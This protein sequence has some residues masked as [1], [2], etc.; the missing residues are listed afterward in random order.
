MPFSPTITTPS[1]LMSSYNSSLRPFQ[2][3]YKVTSPTLSHSNNLH[4]TYRRTGDAGSRD[5]WILGKGGSEKD[6]WSVV[7]GEKRYWDSKL[8]KPEFRGKCGGAAANRLTEEHIVTRL[9]SSSS[10]AHATQDGVRKTDLLQEQR[11]EKI[12]AVADNLFREYFP[13]IKIKE[14]SPETLS[15]SR[16]PRSP[17][18]SP[19]RE[20]KQSSPQT[21][22]VNRTS[23]VI[24][25]SDGVAIPEPPQR[26]NALPSS[27]RRLNTKLN[28]PS[29]V[30]NSG[31]Q[32]SQLRGSE[33]LRQSIGMAPAGMPTNGAY[34]HK[35]PRT[36]PS[37]RGKQ[38]N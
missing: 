36:P 6:G 37:P 31:R 26:L 7:H 25:G 1:V 2:R 12:S 11:R 29:V 10:G 24:K 13:E 27:P 8:G 15:V 34:H 28:P 30:G 18:T 19:R 38:P 17:E 14:L 33:S 23:K 9:G 22:G 3:S 4:G 32:E 21:M 16:S 20:Q 5:N 35:L